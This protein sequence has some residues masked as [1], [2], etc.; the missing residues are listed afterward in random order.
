MKRKFILVLIFI[1]LSTATFAHKEWVH[2]YMVQE[3]AKYL[4]ETRG[5]NTNIFTKRDFGIGYGVN[6]GDVFG[7]QNQYWYTDYPIVVGAWKEDD[8]DIVWKYDGG[9]PAYD[10]SACHFW[11]ADGGDAAKTWL[12]Y[13]NYSFRAENAWT[14]AKMMLFYGG[15]FSF[16]IDY[17]TTASFDI[18]SGPITVTASV[19]KVE[20]TYNNIFD[21][22]NGNFQV[23]QYH[24]SI[25]GWQ[26]AAHPHNPDQ[27]LWQN[28]GRTIALQILGRVA[29]LLGDMNVPQHAHGK[30]HPCSSP[31]TSPFLNFNLGDYYELKVGDTWNN[32]TNCNATPLLTDYSNN[33]YPNVQNW[34][35][36]TA[37]TDGDIINEI[38]CMN[39][40]DAIHY[41][42]YTVNQ[43]AD[44]FPSGKNASGIGSASN[45][46]GSWAN[47]TVFHSGNN[48][49]P[50]GS[51]HY[52][53]D[54]YS[55]F[56]YTSPTTIDAQQIGDNTFNFT[57]RAIATLFHW[58][59]N[60][61]QP[62]QSNIYLQN[63]F[64]NN[65]QSIIN[66]QHDEA[67]GS[68]YL[69]KVNQYEI[70]AFAVNDIAAGNNVT[71]SYSTGDFVVQNGSKAGFYAGN[72]IHLTDGFKVENGAEFIAKIT[73]FPCW[74]PPV[75][76]GLFNSN[77][78]PVII[79][80]DNIDK[81]EVPKLF[82]FPNPFTQTTTLQFTNTANEEFT[83]DVFDITGRVVFTMPKITGTQYTFNR[84]NLAEGIYLLKLKSN[85]KSYIERLVVQD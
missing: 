42:F 34:N 28:S 68:I 1:N 23:N 16:I 39:D 66:F 63:C 58:F 81:V 44:F 76:V 79:P 85:T 30:M 29:H 31:A 9:S 75:R 21:L 20:L 60:K 8:E 17:S 56:N 67:N 49:L 52:I 64:T 61:I 74:A 54:L 37:A 70:K 5:I 82:L 69:K 43:M 22:Y 35:H 12:H 57:I 55:K 84:N 38:M 65:V 33:I 14:A 19:D 4:I 15:S 27:Y 24:N 7:W 40:E 72:S 25:L 83:L 62:V 3:A 45:C 32:S 53:N 47:N 50:N 59:E 11:V 48:N 26:S 6:G 10:A 18:L 46:A 80:T 36:T 13:S 41:L 78:N 51:N 73:P 71:A 2:Q 77:N